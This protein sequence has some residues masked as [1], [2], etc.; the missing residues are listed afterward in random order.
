MHNKQR[1]YTLRDAEEDT[2]TE[3]R[4]MLQNEKVISEDG[5]RELIDEIVEPKIPIHLDRL[6]HFAL[7]NLRLVREE[8]EWK[9]GITTYECLQ[10]AIYRHLIDIALEEVDQVA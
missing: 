10:E 6:L 2:R 4:E 1:D 9:P 3:V 7:D 8:I 5:K